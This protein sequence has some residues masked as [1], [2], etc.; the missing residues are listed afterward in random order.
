M[1]TIIHHYEPGDKQRICPQETIIT[2]DVTGETQRILRGASTTHQ[3]SLSGQS[4]RAELLNDRA[5][6]ISNIQSMRDGKLP[7]NEQI[8][9]AIDQLLNSRVIEN[10]KKSMSDDG[11]ILLK[12]FQELLVILQKALQEKNRDELFQSMIY[13][14]RKSEESIKVDKNKLRKDQQDIQGETQLGGQAI[15]KIAKMFLFN[16][17]FRDL[18]T[19]ILTIAQQTMGG[20]AQ[21]GGQMISDKM[22]SLSGVHQNSSKSKESSQDK[23][24]NNRDSNSRQ[25]VSYDQDNN[26]KDKSH[27]VPYAAL[28]GATVGSGAAYLATN[29]NRNTSN[30][31]SNNLPN[32]HRDFLAHRFIDPESA[33][34]DDSGNALQDEQNQQSSLDNERLNT[35][36]RRI[37][38]D[39]DQKE[40]NTGSTRDIYGERL[41]HGA[42]L[43]SD[44]GINDNRVRKLVRQH[45]ENTSSPDSDN[46]FIT[47]ITDFQPTDENGNPAPAASANMLSVLPTASSNRVDSQSYPQR[48]IADQAFLTNTSLVHPTRGSTNAH[49]RAPHDSIDPHERSTGNYLSTKSTGAE[50]NPY[51]RKASPSLPTDTTNQRN[52]I[53]NN[54]SVTGDASGTGGFQYGQFYGGQTGLS[55]FSSSQPAY[56]QNQ[57]SGTGY[58]GSTLINPTEE[59]A[60]LRPGSHVDTGTGYDRVQSKHSIPAEQINRY[61]DDADNYQEGQNAKDQVKRHAHEY[62]GEHVIDRIGNQQTQL[63]Q[64]QQSSFSYQTLHNVCAGSIHSSNTAEQHISLLPGMHVS[65]AN[66][67]R[68][69]SKHSVPAEEI[70][71]YLNNPSNFQGQGSNNQVLRHAHEFKG[72]HVMDRLKTTTA[73]GGGLVTKQKQQ[74]QAFVANTAGLESQ[75]LG[76]SAGKLSRGLNVHSAGLMGLAGTFGA[77]DTADTADTAGAAGTAGTAGAAG[78]AGAAGVTNTTS[79][80]DTDN[81]INT[82]STT[83]TNGTND[84]AH[85]A[86]SA[87][88]TRVAGIAG[89]A[90]AAGA[91]GGGAAA[92][93]GTNID[94]GLSKIHNDNQRQQKTDSDDKNASNEYTQSNDQS[95]KKDTSISANKIVNKLKPQTKSNETDTES[96]SQQQETS[97]EEIITKLKEILTTVQ[98]NPEYQQSIQTIISLFGFW[99][100]RLSSNQSMDRRKSSAV[101]LSERGEYYKNVASYEAKTIIEDWAQGKSMDPIIQKSSTLYNKLKTDDDLRSLYNEIT[102]YVKRLLKDPG[103]VSSDESTE[104]GKRL[105]KQSRQSSLEKYRSDMNGLIQETSDIIKAISDDEI[106][107]DISKKVKSIHQHL[108]YDSNGNA[109]FKP[110]LLND[111][112]ITLLPALIEQI[113][114]VPLPQIV[115]S[116]KQF[117]IAVENMVLEGDTLM[118]NIFEIKA[119]DYLRF[120]PNIS[121]DYIN[122][123]SLY[124]H[125]NGIQTYMDDVVFYY[126][127]KIGFPRLSDYG[128][129]SLKTGGSGLNISMKIGSDSIDQAHT[130]RIDQCHCTIDKLNIKVMNCK[131]DI[132]YKVFNPMLTSIIK[133]QVSKAIEEKIVTLFQ[134]SDEKITKRLWDKQHINE[135]GTTRNYKRPGFFSHLITVLNQKVAN[136]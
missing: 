76:T 51:Y 6:T 89:I 109:A 7:N 68:I 99:S 44:Y 30:Q 65:T 116:D 49:I 33:A 122:S 1:T 98:K 134:K 70:N 94:T 17:Q 67:D 22:G 46:G 81:M 136:I 119:D 40:L 26:S 18:L 43:R 111:I 38:G 118:P 20:A 105:V 11:Q 124:I 107:K 24:V 87:H 64:Q 135:T 12:D 121:L 96:S 75:H 126:K 34:T 3:G 2:D 35:N 47:D 102:S 77:I 58:D 112:R 27:N 59:H 55:S 90:G 108:W 66:Y 83:N 79:T 39:Y 80:T 14:V 133:R 73:P 125:M 130:F 131:H 56:S 86:H 92:A 101:E 8:N 28:G 110:H 5:S 36:T 62:N 128:V 123:Q 4:Q 72:E 32:K 97:A 48:T 104:D 25:H 82:A 71:K 127:R 23:D 42:I 120:S 100:N 63:Q 114:Y 60:S 74:S 88:A 31:Y 29:Y 15:L 84:A 132:L 19:Q 41:H 13:H 52:N 61:L 57:P 54:Q 45:N 78:A 10:N 21:A 103:Y 16:S 129:I 117:E 106:S 115:Y 93:G 37:P 85:S 113:K 69:Q 91:A 50:V 95:S 53:N 9:N